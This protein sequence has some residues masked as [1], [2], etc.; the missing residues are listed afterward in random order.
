LDYAFEN[1]DQLTNEHIETL[2]RISELMKSIDAE[3]FSKLR[4]IYNITPQI[5]ITKQFSSQ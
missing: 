1:N 3:N 5:Q 4:D 2:N